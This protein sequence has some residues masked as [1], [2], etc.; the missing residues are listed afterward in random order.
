VATPVIAY[1]AKLPGERSYL[2]VPHLQ[3]AAQR[4]RQHQGR[5]PSRPSTETL[6]RQPSASIIGMARSRIL[7]ASYAVKL[8]NDARIY[9][10]SSDANRRSSRLVRRP[11]RP[12]GSNSF[13][14]WSRA[15]MRSHLR[16]ARQHVAQV[17]LAGDG[18]LA[19]GF[20][21]TMGV[22]LSIFSASANVTASA[23][24]RPCVASC[25]TCPAGD[26]GSFD[27]GRESPTGPA[28][29]SLAE[30]CRPADSSISSSHVARRFPISHSGNL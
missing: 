8:G 30:S 3:G 10:S 14:N 18:L 21:Q 19:R 2:R 15:Q 11:D 9:F 17:L 4:I 13:A 25:Q 12:F 5:P 29:V 7:S 26:A 28:H 22:T 23:M 27:T 1:D 16:I 24:I 6:S 20:D